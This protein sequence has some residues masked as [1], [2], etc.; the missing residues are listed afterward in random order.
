[1]EDKEEKKEENTSMFE[2][3]FSIGLNFLPY[4]IKGVKSI[5]SDDDDEKKNDGRDLEEKFSKKLDELRLEKEEM[6]K[7]N[8]EYENSIRK[9]KEMMQNNLEQQKMKEL[10]RQ[11]ELM[12]MENKRRQEEIEENKKTQEAILQCKESLNNQFTKGIFQAL[13]NYK[14]EEEKW[15][16]KLNDENIHKKLSLYKKKLNRLFQDLYLNEKIQEKMTQEF[17]NIVKKTA[18][19]KE[20]NKMNFMIIGSSGV[21]KSTLINQL[22]GEELAQEGSG[23]RCTTIGTKYTSK[24]FPCLT[25]YD[26]VGTEIGQGHTLEEVQKETLDEITKNLNIN[27]PNEHIHCIIYCTTSN[28]IFKD[29]LKVILKIREKY[30]GKRLPIV[31][32]FT[33]AIDEEEVESKKE[34]INEFLK[35]YGEEISDDIFGITFIKV[36]AKE[37]ITKKLGKSI[38]DP[39]FGLSDLMST[40]Y[41]KGEKSY[42][43]AIKNSL[44]EI[45]KNTFYKYIQN[46]VKY[47]SDDIN[48]YLYLA[49]KFEPNFTD[50]ISYSFEKFTDIVNK[51]GV[52]ENELQ[53]LENYLGNKLLDNRKM[54]INPPRK[55]KK[56]TEDPDEDGKTCI[57]CEKKPVVEY[58]CECGAYACEGCYLNEFNY[59]DSVKCILCGKSESYICQEETNQGSTVN[60]SD[61]YNCITTK[62]N[63][64]GT[65]N[66]I[67]DNKENDN[68][69]NDDS[70]SIINILPNNLDIE[71]KNTIFE[72]VNGFKKEMIEIM[73]AKF[74]NFI[75]NETQK[76]YYTI[77]EKYNESLMNKG[78]NMK[79]AMKSKEEL[80]NEAANEIKNQLQKPAEENFLK[81]MAS[82]LFQDIIKIF[83]NEMINKVM[84]FINNLNNNEEVNTFLNSFDMIPS[85]NESLKIQGQFDDY[86]KKLRQK[87]TESQ[88]KA[89]KYQY[90]D[91]E[92]DCQGE[93]STLSSNN[94]SDEP[95]STPIESQ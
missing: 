91:N 4:I 15:L 85:E 6:E 54:K 58:K 53:K 48:F 7:R 95:A 73:S 82:S 47:L 35:E 34:A 69:D 74:E 59:H 23:K 3:V 67:N 28:R 19:K 29:E 90:E 80:M 10:E 94:T 66:D 17:I 27:D 14:K 84:E 38:C 87:E 71:S 12:E 68:N 26:S 11:K 5:V 77:L 92:S 9:L 50:F 30:D 37:K 81:S 21:G 16:N 63:E 52:K 62:G 20:L 78:M 61:N 89:I 36:H 33:R 64:Q 24:N 32:V 45:A 56:E 65:I 31:I 1:M 8:R 79:G 60:P 55:D 13:R 43:I 25:L 2:K 40:C 88:E 93:S 22:F 86:I 18:N 51:E 75:Q 57:Y 44:V 39:C 46:V 76:I 42:K 49:K 70:D 72:F 83:N 41:K